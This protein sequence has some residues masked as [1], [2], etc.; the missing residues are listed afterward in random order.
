[1]PEHQN[2]LIT[3]YHINVTSLESGISTFYSSTTTTVTATGL[4][5]YTTYS[6]IVAAE[7]NVGRGP[8]T[9]VVLITTHEDG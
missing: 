9:T 2:G 3:L 4:S 1:M 5:P 8:Y 6:C 7:T